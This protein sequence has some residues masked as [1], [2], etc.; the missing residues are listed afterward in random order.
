MPA[1]QH[2][3]NRKSCTPVSPCGLPSPK[4][5]CSSSSKCPIRQDRSFGS[6]MKANPIRLARIRGAIW[7]WVRR[8][9][10]GSS[11][12]RFFVRSHGLEE[13]AVQGPSEYGFVQSPDQPRRAA[14]VVSGR[15][16]FSI[17]WHLS[18]GPHSSSAG[19]AVSFESCRKQR[20]IISYNVP[21]YRTCSPDSTWGCRAFF[22]RHVTQVFAH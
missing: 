21:S 5:S 13:L 18:T 2:C 16:V 20:D 14:R 11:F 10:D 12:G 19:D 15:D 1:Q 6:S 8:K 22:L 4:Y 9:L 3:W 17:S 7:L